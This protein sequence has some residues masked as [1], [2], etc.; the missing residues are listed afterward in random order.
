MF[1]TTFRDPF[2]KL[3]HCASNRS[4]RTSGGPRRRTLLHFEELETRLALAVL[5]PTPI[6]DISQLKGNEAESSIA[7]NPKSPNDTFASVISHPLGSKDW[8]IWVADSQAAGKWNGDY[9]RDHGK[10]SK[11]LPYSSSDPQLAFDALGNLFL[12]YNTDTPDLQIGTASAKAAEAKKSNSLLDDTREW[13]QDVWK[14]MF[15][16]ITNGAGQGQIREIAGNTPTALT[17]K[18]IWDGDR[19]PQKNS[20]YRIRNLTQEF[21]FSLD[22]KA[23]LKPGA[24]AEGSTPDTLRDEKFNFAR[25]DQK[26]KA[27]TVY[28]QITG[29]SGKGQIRRIESVEEKNIVVV[30]A[31]WTN[32]VPDA[33]SQYEIL[34]TGRAISLVRSRDAGKTFKLIQLFKGAVGGRITFPDYPAL[35][36]SYPNKAATLWLAYADVDGIHVYGAPVKDLSDG[37][38]TF[39]GEQVI[40]GDRPNGQL[41]NPHID[42]GPQG[43]VMVTALQGFPDKKDP[44]NP[45][46]MIPV[47]SRI[48]IASSKED[49]LRS[50]LILRT[51]V[52]DDIWDRPS[53]EPRVQPNRNLIVQP[54]LAWDRSGSIVKGDSGRV[55]LVYENATDEKKRNAGDYDIFLRWSDDLGATWSDKKLVNAPSKM[56]Q[57]E[58]SIA[59]DQTTGYVAIAWY[60]ARKDEANTKVEVYA[61]VSRDGGKD[62]ETPVLISEQQSSAKAVHEADPT[63]DHDFGEYLGLAYNNGKFS[64]T[65]ADN[66]DSA[67]LG[68]DGKKAKNPD[69][70]KAFD[71]YTRTVTVEK[72]GVGRGLEGQQ[73]NGVALATFTDTGSGTYSANVDWG[74]GSPLD[75]TT[76]SIS[77]SGSTDT[78]RG[79][80]TYASPGGYTVT[81][82]VSRSGSSIVLSSTILVT[83]SALSVAGQSFSGTAW[84]ALSNQ[85]VATFTDANPQSQASDFLASIDWGDGSTSLG[86][87]TY[88]SGTYS[89]RGTHTYKNGGAFP[90]SVTISDLVGGTSASVSGT[91]TISN[92]VTAQAV[93]LS[94]TENTPLSNVNVA[95]FTAPAGTYTASIDWGDGHVTS[96]N[97]SWGGSGTCQVSGSNLYGA[98]GW[99]PLTVAISSGGTVAAVVTA[100]VYVAPAALHATGTS[101]TPTQGQAL[102]NV[103]VARFTDDNPIRSVGD[104]TADIDWGDSSGSPEGSASEPGVIVAEGGGSFAVLGS[105]TYNHSGSFPISVS[106]QNSAGASAG[107][108]NSVSVAAAAPSVSGLDTIWG[109]VQGGTPV[110][111]SGSNLYGAT[112]VSFGGTAATAFTVNDDGTITA[113]A[114]A[115]SAGTYDVQVTTAAGTSSVTA[116]DQYTALAAA[117]SITS[118]SAT[119]GPTGGGNSVVIT[120]TSLAGT[121]QLMFGSLPAVSFSVDSNTQITAVVPASVSGAVSVT[122]TNPY[123][124]SSSTTYTYQATAPSVTGLDTLAGPAAGAN[125]ITILGTNLNGATAVKFNST[126]AT[127]FT[128]LSST[129]IVA[130]VPALSAGLYDVQVTTPYGTSSTSSADQYTA[131]AAPTITNLS[132]SSGP[133]GGGNT[134]TLTG[135]GFTSA[136]A[137]SFGG[138]AASSFTVNSDTSLTV[139]VPPGS[140]GAVG[141]VVTSTGGDSAAAS[142]TY[143]AT[144]PSITSIGPNRGPLEGGTSVVITGANLTEATQ[145]LFGTTA[146]SSFSIDSAT[147]ITA[148]APAGTAG[149][150]SITVVTPYGSSNAATFT[151]ASG[152]APE[153]TGASVS[154]TTIPYG[155]MTGGTVVTLTGSGFTA[156]TQV[157]FGDQLASSWTIVSDTQIQATAPAHTAGTVDLSVTTP[158]GTSSASPFDRFSYLTAVPAIS[159]LSLTTGSTA[160]GDT[161]VLSGSGFTGATRIAFGN[162]LAD[163]TVGDDGTIT[164]TSPIQASGA[165]NVTVTTPAGT[166]STG[167]QTVFT[168]SAASGLPTVSS[169]ST[170]SGPSGGSTSVTITGTG[171]TGATRVAFANATATSFVINSATSITAIAPAG[172]AGTVDVT[173][174]TTA[175]IS[176]AVSGDHF[177]YQSS[178]PT[179]SGLSIGTGPTSGGTTVVISG[180]NFNGTTAVNFGS[181]AATS[182]VVNSP[183]SITAVAPAQAAG[184]VQVTVTTPNG[185]SATSGSSQFQYV[186]ASP[187]VVSS[188]S[189]GFGPMAGGTTVLVTGTGF[190]GASQVIFGNVAG[191]SLTVLSGTQL[192]VV[193]PSEVSGAVDV[194][195]VTPA[196]ASA[197][198]AGD[199]FL[200]TSIGPAISSLGTTSGPTSGGTVVLL[201]GSNLS[202]ATVVSFGNT[203]AALFQVLSDTQIRAVSPLAQPGTI[204]VTV[205]TSSGTSPTS[206]ATNFTYMTTSSTT[207]TVTGLSQTSGPSS[208]GNTLTISGTNL[209]GTQQVLFGQTAASFTLVS[210]TS[211][212]V[213]VPAGVVGTVDVTVTTPLGIS[214]PVSADQYTYQSAPPTVTGVSPSTATTA[215]NVLVTITGTN[216]STV[217]GVSFGTTPVYNFTIVSNTTITAVAPISAAGTVDVLVTNTDGTSSPSSGSPFTF[218]STSSTPTVT[219]LGTTQGPTGGGTSVGITGTNFTNVTGVFFGSTPATSYVV[220]SSTSITAVSPAAV[221]GAVNVSVATSAGISSTGSGNVFTYQATSPSVSGLSPSSGPSAGGS[222]V[223]ITGTNLNGATA[224]KFGTTNAVSF[225]VD[226]PTQITA[227]A[228]SGS[229]G[230][231]NVTVTTPYGTSATSGASQFIYVATPTVTGLSSSSGSTSGGASLNISGTNFTGL[232]SVSFGGVPAAALTV[233]SS[234]SITVTTPATA[235]GT[236][237]VVVTTSTGSS[238]TST[239]DQYTFVAP[240]PSISGLSSTGGPVAGS[241]SL[242][243]SGTGFTGATAVYFGGVAATSFTVVS[244]TQITV[245]IP[246]ATA[247]GTVDVQVV[248]AYGVNSATVSADQYTYYGVPSISSLSPNSDTA[249]GGVPV[250]ISGVNLSGASAV[251]FGSYA[252]ASFTVLNDTTIIATTPAQATGTVNVTVT[253]PGGTSAGASFSYTASRTV[254][255]TGPTSGDWSTTS[256][257]SIGSLPGAGDDVTIPSGTTVTHST[258]SDSIHRLTVQGSL[259]ISG[260]TLSVGA[261]STAANLTLSGGTLTGAGAITVSG[262]FSWSGGV[263][264]GSGSMTISSSATFTLNSSSSALTLSGRTVN[265]AGTANWT[266][267]GALQLNAGASWNNSGLF[268]AQNNASITT[269]SSATFSNSGTF[270]KSVGTG[271]TT[272]GSGASFTNTGQVD[273]QTGTLSLGAGSSSG[274]MSL[275]SGTTLSFTGG[276]TL[277]N[278]STITGSGSV[279][280]SSGT[281]TLGGSI[282]ASSVTIQ[283]GATVSGSATIT[284]SVTN[285]GTIYIGGPGATGQLTINGNF[286]Q[287]SQ[288]ILNMEIA[289]LTAATQFD[290]LAISGTAT[291]AG[292]LNVQLLNGFIPVSGN[293]FALLTFG[294]HSGSFGTVTGLQENGINFTPQ[295]DPGDY[296]LY[297]SLLLEEEG[298]EDLPSTPTPPAETVRLLAKV[299][300]DF[301]LQQAFARA[302]NANVLPEDVFFAEP[303]A[304]TESASLIAL[305]TPASSEGQENRAWNDILSLAFALPV[306]GSYFEI[307]KH[308]LRRDRGEKSK[309]K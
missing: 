116:A 83:D 62:F 286:T 105:H 220:N 56:T 76:P 167:T 12:A 259:V 242:S 104:Y 132:S 37:L 82:T 203:P 148:T 48:I 6:V 125:T 42:V 306:F 28:I 63:Y 179:V 280:F 106:I 139:T 161:V 261:T 157:L 111:I 274:T 187:P 31:K 201:N 225:S 285:S 49:G 99:Y 232:V 4:R 77:S 287:T 227:T 288:G 108:N 35:A 251:N 24:S 89:V 9:L 121:T 176:S 197:I 64:V 238:T 264:S 173:V 163:F 298:A 90:V 103:V 79:S 29:G 33:T 196:G 206:T 292:T 94:A 58:P 275:A 235:P 205:V 8:S 55:Y 19:V 190:T 66:S 53:T 188:V 72:K 253:T 284:S 185:T 140:A 289:G 213:T 109:P 80:H 241:G 217:T 291:L 129:S 211:L 228:P 170:S 100:D 159:G 134:I 209:A 69:G 93:P 248:G 117:P 147:Q 120:G 168:Y 41:Q 57:F 25:L 278:A 70:T 172:V 34:E 7:K 268:N 101:L 193:A 295:Y 283:S 297:L 230:V 256:Y 262:S 15:L 61:T 166:S 65:W 300:Q 244:N 257:W 218:T 36:T 273:L 169:L 178:A 226:S 219:N 250:T 3:F 192:T 142:Y 208:G 27:G 222:V 184:T 202:G 78:L 2:G 246:A 5:T 195:V 135:T 181:L 32:G 88:S 14:G 309:A 177:T 265:N 46:R 146:A 26:V 59:V 52:P 200:Y 128:V 51:P 74:D 281:N 155:P 124:T 303:E 204:A 182:F 102:S 236:V 91:A 164:A 307:R 207:P 189:P 247:P 212:S 45:A 199:S 294:S 133:T 110:T 11:S 158:Y 141:V 39:R 270:R 240:T 68:P 115:L 97:I 1:R 113:I 145:V 22:L 112:A 279:V 229:A 156:A 150:V 81:S 86:A 95:S 171:F 260:G 54:K 215:G 18:S 293:R 119:S 194:T 223:V 87:V 304:L 224:V 198:T 233:N 151:Y 17:I 13:N 149:N 266:G 131:V 123:G 98:A 301:A 114:P 231:T 162:V 165:V 43:Q 180:A 269:S 44:T 174:T 67:Q 122:A 258:G 239:A 126:A 16:E 254:S 271:S 302:D 107:V 137:V 130:T 40:K 276:F 272:F 92:S 143:N 305:A 296:S 118:L 144:S 60:D 21:W 191:T 299:D 30:N 214:A 249:A 96:Q 85:Q 252:A 245:T 237:D 234:T 221:S 308:T 10:G 216:F 243:L 255:W 38:L 277:T 50:D 23:G 84:S 154:G 290:Q 186:S 136:Y 160:G 153:I 138:T 20:Q 263:Q 175:G 73:L 210:S 152:V 127:S 47:G 75:S 282:T 267:S 71:L 183:T